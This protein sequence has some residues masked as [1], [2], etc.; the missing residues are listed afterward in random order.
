[1]KAE[2]KY[3]KDIELALRQKYIKQSIERAKREVALEKKIDEL[4]KTKNEL[5]KFI[6][7]LKTP[8]DES[9]NNGS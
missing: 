7:K 2:D 6:D 5:F 4:L 3:Y 1:M 9:T 8:K